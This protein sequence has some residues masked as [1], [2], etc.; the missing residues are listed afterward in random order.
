[1][2]KLLTEQ[3]GVEL[4][5]LVFGIISWSST[6]LAFM[7]CAKLWWGESAQTETSYMTAGGLHLSH[8]TL[9]INSIAS[10]MVAYQVL[11]RSPVNDG[12]FGASTFPVVLLGVGLVLLEFGI[13]VSMANPAVIV[14]FLSVLVLA[15]LLVWHVASPLGDLFPSRR[16]SRTYRAQ[17][18]LSS[19][20]TEHVHSLRDYVHLPFLF[21]IP[22]YYTRQLD[23]VVLDENRFCVYLQSA[24]LAVDREPQTSDAVLSPVLLCSP[25]ESLCALSEAWN[26][27]LDSRVAEW[28]YLFCF[29]SAFISA[30]VTS[31]QVMDEL[32]TH[33]TTL[34]FFGGGFGLVSSLIF[35]IY[36][37]I[38]GTR[39]VH[40]PLVWLQER[41]PTV[42]SPWTM[43]S[44]PAATIIWAVNLFGIAL[45]SHWQTLSQGEGE[46][47]PPMPAQSV[48]GL[49]YI[50]VLFSLLCLA[51]LCWISVVL[52]RYH[53]SCL[54]LSGMSRRMTL[55]NTQ[56]I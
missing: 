2:P 56:G 33:L 6:F 43:F 22:L 39:S 50:S 12:N 36:F 10:C 1:M 21:F 23:T 5:I 54:N 47:P 18:F 4:H 24:S 16:T 45:Y 25:P 13:F 27:Y 44:F 55:F 3:R 52:H 34:A 42:W 49:R 46:N 53:K 26:H 41:T 15:T 11:K 29:S 9:V 31:V 51:G 20:E 30:L 14:L 32:P 38:E 28:K 8:L 19:F 7:W 35:P 37:T 40:S 17:S 48:A